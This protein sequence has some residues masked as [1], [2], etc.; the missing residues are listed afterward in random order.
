MDLFQSILSKRFL[1]FLN[2]NNYNDKF[3]W[4]EWVWDPMQLTLVAGWSRNQPLPI[5]VL[6]GCTQRHMR[7][8]H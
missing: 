5:A 4:P 6:A 2:L 8:G 7:E 1:L 3:K